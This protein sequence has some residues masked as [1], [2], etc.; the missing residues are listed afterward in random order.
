M[1]LLK[2]FEIFT[3]KHNLFEPGNKIL[4]AVSG[5]VDSV[6]LLDLFWNIHSRWNLIL[7]VAHLNHS[8]R[9]EM[10]DRDE[11][12]VRNLTRHYG[13]PFYSSKAA[14]KEYSKTRKL[15]LEEGAREVRFNFLESVLNRLRHDR[16][17]L[18][19]H[20]NDQ[21]ET[22]LMNLLRGSG[23]RGIGGIRPK[24]NQIIHPLLFATRQEI[25]FYA[26]KNKLNFV[27]DA[28]NQDKK[29]LR[30]RIRW[31][32]LKKLESTVGSH[33][34]SSLCRAGSL[35]QEAEVF[36]EQEARKVR[37]KI[38]TIGSQNE[39]ILDIYKFLT[40]FKV[41][42]K[43]ILVQI[44]ENF[45][46]EEQVH[47]SVIG[48][49][50]RLAEEG[51]SGGVVELGRD[52]KVVRTRNKLVFFKQCFSLPETPVNVGD[53]V[54]LPQGGARF[55]ATVINRKRKEIVFSSDKNIEYLDYD[56]LSP[57]LLLRPYQRGD[58]FIP[59]GMKGKKK[60]QDFFVDEGIPNYLRSSVLL[61]ISGRDILWVIGHRI[62]NRFK[63]TKKTE[64]VLKVEF[65]PPVRTEK[66]VEDSSEQNYLSP[67]KIIGNELV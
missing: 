64:R 35:V 36:I 48:R 67:P 43:V 2:K 39:I 57:P 40:Y 59:L 66:N 18:A 15:S 13:L 27:I 63:V 21:A 56:L 34:V 17:A 28:S 5:G 62:D 45:S 16:L 33:V 55:E 12:F 49:I 65:I 7:A 14:V 22:I 20:A 54:V 1:D 10:A 23:L 61:L 44:L 11:I 24:R 25:E 50:L 6:V 19:H 60:L 42:Q 52:L 47:S 30:N 51:R 53:S 38:T 8:L 41:I 4:L 31:D 3:L 58:W 46:P 37:Q 9:G 29:F 26:E 32:V